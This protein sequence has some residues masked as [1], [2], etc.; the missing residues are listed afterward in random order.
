MMKRQLVHSSLL[1]ITAIYSLSACAALNE[2]GAKKISITEIFSSHLCNINEQSI[3]EIKDKPALTA[4][5]NKANNHQLNAKPQ[6]L[7]SIDFNA[8]N[9]YLIAMGSRPNAGYSLK[10]IGSEANLYNDQLNLPIA[11]ELPSKDAMYAQMMASPCTLI[12]L[13][14]GTYKEIKIEGWD[15]L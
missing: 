12:S 8:A 13:P 1:V 9:I 15:A 6:D 11:V 7:S 4:V 5:L 14:A 2:G 10:F 3:T